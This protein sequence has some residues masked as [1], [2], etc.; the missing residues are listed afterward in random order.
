MQS[1]CIDSKGNHRKIDFRIDLHWLDEVA[2]LPVRPSSPIRFN[3]TEP[4]KVVIEKPKSELAKLNGTLQ[5]HV[6][7]II[8]CHKVCF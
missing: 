2:P 1:S 7:S 3:Q 5:G 4:I 6:D 8:F